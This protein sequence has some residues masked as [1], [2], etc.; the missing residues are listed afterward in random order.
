MDKTDKSEVDQ[1]VAEFFARGGSI[2]HIPLGHK[3]NQEVVS[4]MWGKP[5]KKVEE[6]V[7]EEKP[8]KEKKAKK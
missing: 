6:P 5:K 1:L 2:Q 7:V 4:R 3:S 8:K